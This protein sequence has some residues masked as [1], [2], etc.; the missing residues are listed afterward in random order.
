M[1]YHPN[2]IQVRKQMRSVD[3]LKDEI[4]MREKINI[5]FLVPMDGFMQPQWTST[6]S[7]NFCIMEPWFTQ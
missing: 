6:L 1:H 2:I 3:Y 4:N 7:G 5:F